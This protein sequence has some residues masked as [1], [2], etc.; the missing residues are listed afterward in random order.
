MFEGD[1]EKAL[2]IAR[3]KKGLVVSCGINRTT[4]GRFKLEITV[5]TNYDNLTRNI[6]K[7]LDDDDGEK[8]AIREV[9][10]SGVNYFYEDTKDRTDN[11]EEVFNSYEEA[12][13][14]LQQ[15]LATV[16]EY[17]DKVRAGEKSFSSYVII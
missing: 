13:S 7:K 4:E 16:K 5:I 12:Y 10:N 11:Y 3:E 14:K 8:S 1:K 9:I 2:T 15:I 17:R 6:F